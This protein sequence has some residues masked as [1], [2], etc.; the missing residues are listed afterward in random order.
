M[1]AHPQQPLELSRAIPALAESNASKSED[2]IMPIACFKQIDR[3]LTVNSREYVLLREPNPAP[4][5]GRFTSP[6]TFWPKAPSPRDSFN[7]FA[8]ISTIGCSDMENK[9]A[10][11]ALVDVLGNGRQLVCNGVPV[12]EWG[13]CQT[14]IA[15]SKLL[16]LVY[17]WDLNKEFKSWDAELQS[18]RHNFLYFVVKRSEIDSQ[19]ITLYYDLAAL[20][21]GIFDTPHKTTM[22]V[23]YV[24]ADRESCIE[25]HPDVY[26]EASQWKNSEQIEAE[27]HA[28]VEMVKTQTLPIGAEDDMEQQRKIKQLLINLQKFK[29]TLQ[30]VLAETVGKKN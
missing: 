13:L 29:S 9:A 18:N 27:Y 7:M 26:G 3:C 21:Y 1:A 2:E 14:R 4:P 23:P 15:T 6:Q 5:K 30:L 12:Q 25:M 19:P 22:P 10:A 11:M 28:L 20:Q 16:T 8:R 17:S 24:F